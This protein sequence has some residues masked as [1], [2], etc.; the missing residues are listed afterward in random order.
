[1]IGEEDDA[2]ATKWTGDAEVEPGAGEV[3]ATPAHDA[4]AKDRNAK[5]VLTANFV[6]TFTPIYEKTIRMNV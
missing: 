6:K 5:R 2:D 1:M 4:A 3:V